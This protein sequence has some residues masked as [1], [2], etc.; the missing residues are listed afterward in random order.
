MDR[1]DLFRF[2]EE[3]YSF[4]EDEYNQ[5]GYITSPTIEKVMIR[6]GSHE[7]YGLFQHIEF[8]YPMTFAA[9]K[10]A[11]REAWVTDRVPEDDGIYYFES[12]GL[13][14]M[15][16][17]KERKLYNSL[18]KT[19]TIYRGCHKDEAKPVN[20]YRGKFYPYF[21]LSWTLDREVAEFFAFRGKHFSKE[22]GRVYSIRIKKDQMLALF[23]DRSEYEV[24]YPYSYAGFFKP[25][26]LVTD[27][28]TEYY[29]RFMESKD[30]E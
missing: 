30:K 9:Y 1:Q 25:F 29:A 18:P 24:I 21:H 27:E 5:K 12:I 10:N 2:H 20:K 26:S 22:D 14:R 28:P 4:L 17:T 13:D 15:L 11:F 19:I 8:Y 3:T 23:L 7:R 6:V 16:N